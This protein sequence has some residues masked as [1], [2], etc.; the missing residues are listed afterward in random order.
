MD[1]I[2]GLGATGHPSGCT[3]A[4]RKHYEELQKEA[5]AE[6]LA[7]KAM[8]LYC[9]NNPNA[10]TDKCSA[11]TRKIIDDVH[12]ASM[13]RQQREYEIWLEG[14]ESRKQEVK[15]RQEALLRAE[16]EENEKQRRAAAQQRYDEQERRN[17]VQL[18][19]QQAALQRGA[20]EF[21]RRTSQFD[22]ERA[23]QRAQQQIAEEQARRI[24]QQRARPAVVNVPVRSDPLAPAPAPSQTAESRRAAGLPDDPAAAACIQDDDCARALRSK[25]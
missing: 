18:A 24:A 15:E 1:C 4:D 25:H 10:P 12:A 2:S 16:L 19:D 17:A 3:D 23:A 9:V 8:V 21:S 7:E 5:N 14:A 6:A 13:A 22:A 20:D 11:E